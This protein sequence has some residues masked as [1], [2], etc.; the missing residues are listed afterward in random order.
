M[1]S[2][3]GIIA[4]QDDFTIN[5][6]TLR[7]S[8]FIIRVCQLLKKQLLKKIMCDFILKELRN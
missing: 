6:N 5:N 8:L 2:K 4:Y 7:D 1:K 3:K